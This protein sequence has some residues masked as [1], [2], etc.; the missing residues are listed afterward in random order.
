MAAEPKA[1]D[2]TSGVVTTWIVTV[3]DTGVSIGFEVTFAFAR[4]MVSPPIVT[5]DG[6]TVVVTKECAVVAAADCAAKLMVVAI[7]FTFPSAL[8]LG[9]LVC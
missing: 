9:R 8:K 4:L 5:S 6:E 1:G 2:F 3:S 7:V